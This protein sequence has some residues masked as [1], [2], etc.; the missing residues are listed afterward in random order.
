MDERDLGPVARIATAGGRY[1]GVGLHVRPGGHVLSCAHVVA[2]ALGCPDAQFRDE[3]PAGPVRVNFPFGP[4]P[5]AGY[6]ACVADG[7][8]QRNR[9]PDEAEEPSGRVD[10]A[11]LRL[12]AP[13]PG[14]PCADF[15]AD[16]WRWTGDGDA[17][18]WG[19][20]DGSDAGIPTRCTRLGPRTNGR[21]LLDSS[22]RN[23]VNAA[24]RITAGFSGGGVWLDRE[25]RFAG[26]V[27]TEAGGVAA[28]MI[29][30]RVLRAVWPA[31]DPA[32]TTPVAGSDPRDLLCLLDRTAACATLYR[33]L[34]AALP[35]RA[36]LVFFIDGDKR[37]WHDGF[38]AHLRIAGRTQ[39]LPEPV[40]R[41]AELL[42]A[43]E[44]W[45][46]RWEPDLG[47][48]G[49][50]AALVHAL[51]L[52]AATAPDASTLA[53]ALAG[54]G[55]G[56]LLRYDIECE[57]W[58]LGAAERR[59]LRAWLDL[60][61]GL[62]EPAQPLVVLLCLRRTPA[63]ASLAARLR[64]WWGRRFAQP[65]HARVAS[66]ALGP[67]GTQDVCDW[68]EFTVRPAARHR[69]RELDALRLELERE[70]GYRNDLSMDHVLGCERLLRFLATDGSPAP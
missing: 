4:A 63:P 2:D 43:L 61:F 51:G 12:D 14:V 25:R 44:P 9:R 49:L 45:P 54:R 42:A 20:P 8:W 18:T 64:R 58:G 35:P 19:L 16:G 50:Y 28:E 13:A 36:P 10:I 29:P 34:G 53:A 39:P 15:T 7:G 23:T 1:V 68:L 66:I 38:V 6:T 31:L 60:L 17:W 56:L 52:P 30:A 46:L 21:T 57:Y 22:A 65:A 24:I 55:G 47:L 3:P 32:A 41:A 70:L 33:T 27:A 69:A 37:D 5:A 11:V 62:G 59:L 40:R 48:D 67:V 26:L